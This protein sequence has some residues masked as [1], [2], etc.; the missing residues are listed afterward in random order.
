MAAKALLTLLDGKEVL[1]SRL[2]TLRE[3]TFRREPVSQRRTVVALLGLHQFADSGQAQPFD[4]DSIQA[5]VF[6]DRRWVKGIGDLGILIRF[7]AECSPN[8]LTSLANEFDLGNALNIFPDGREA[9]TSELA[10]FL[11]GIS[12]ARLASPGLLPDLTDFAVDTY[13]LLKDN[14]GTGGIFAHAG[15]PGFLQQ[16]FSNRFGTF[17]DQAHAIYA[18]ATFARAFEI[19]EPLADAL[20]CA[21]AIRALQGDKGQWWFLYDKRSCEVVNHYPVRSVYQGGIAP[22]ALMALAEATGQ[23][24]DEAVCSGLSW[25]AGANELG[26]DLR[27]FE[28]GIIWDSIEPKSRIASMRDAAFNIAHRKVETHATNLQ[29]RFEARPDHFGWLLYALSRFGSNDAMGAKAAT[30]G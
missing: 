17:A 26:V 15:T 23:K 27:D 20:N 21:N 9:H 13:R 1:F 8:R 28:S 5:A 24:F 16:P 6:Q 19:E 7:A 30:V 18:L 29:V 22:M 3:R 12:H 25:I 4:L 2:I 14:Q 10:C 11:A